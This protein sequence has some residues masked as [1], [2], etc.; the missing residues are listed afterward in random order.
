M[1][2]RGV[3]PIRGRAAGCPRAG[4]H[5]VGRQSRD[6]RGRAAGR[7]GRQGSPTIRARPCTSAIRTAWWC[8][9]TAATWSCRVTT[10]SGSSRPAAP[11][12]RW[13]AAR[14]GCGALPTVKVPPRA[15]RARGAWRWTR[16][17]AC[18]WPT[19]ATTRCGRSCLPEVSHRAAALR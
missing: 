6:R 17:G 9:R 7:T 3:L 2:P 18:W 10:R 16:T 11:C 8:Y 14:R 19:L 12:P 13:P 15:P 5:R 1:C 4:G